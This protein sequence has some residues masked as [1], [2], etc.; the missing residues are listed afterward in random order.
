V[1]DT[2]GPTTADFTISSDVASGI[3]N[4]IM[5]NNGGPY[6]YTDPNHRLMTWGQSER[7]N[8]NLEHNYSVTDIP[9]STYTLVLYASN[10]DFDNVPAIVTFTVNGG[11]PFTE[12]FT[13][14][15]ASGWDGTL[16][17][18]EEVFVVTGLSGSLTINAAWA[19]NAE[20]GAGLTGFQIVEELNA[21]VPEPST[22]VLAG[23]GLMGL[24][25]ATWRKRQTRD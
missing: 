21:A 19:N 24:G 9:Y 1:N 23:V 10:G 25:L 16:D 3:D 18:N 17:L 20:G 8:G 12:S 11:T 22:I 13:D 15:G 4:W 7:R 6:P 5:Y 14:G 2:D